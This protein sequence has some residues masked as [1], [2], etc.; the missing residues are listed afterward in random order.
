MGWSLRLAFSVRADLGAVPTLRVQGGLRQVGF[1]VRLPCAA[2]ARGNPASLKPSL[3]LHPPPLID[4]PVRRFQ[5]DCFRSFGGSP[6]PTYNPL[7]FS[8]LYPPART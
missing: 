1:P 2:K 6:C 4:F 5:Q 8:L 7:P 3:S